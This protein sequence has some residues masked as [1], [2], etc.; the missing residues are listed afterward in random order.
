M[1]WAT[2]SPT[3]HGIGKGLTFANVS[4]SNHVEI[5]EVGP[6]GMGATIRCV[7][8]MR[9]I[10]RNERF[11][12]ARLGFPRESLRN[13]G[14]GTPQ[15]HSIVELSVTLDVRYLPGLVSRGEER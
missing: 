8:T 1:R 15:T 6:V 13:T 4:P 3:R 14:E 7:E 12:I 10:E 11:D 5:E 2:A 9:K